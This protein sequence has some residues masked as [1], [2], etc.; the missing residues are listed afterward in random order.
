MKLL[1]KQMAQDRN[2]S[3]QQLCSDV[4][5]SY[6]VLTKYHNNESSPTLNTLIKIADRLGCKVQDLFVA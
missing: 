1:I 5:I 6:R 4:G 3:L 2:V